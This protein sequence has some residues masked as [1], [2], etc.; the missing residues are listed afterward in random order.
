MHS[1]RVKLIDGGKLVIPAAMRRELGTATGDS[2]VVDL[3]NGELRVRTLRKVIE[4][5]RAI[6]RRYVPEDRSL[7][8]ELLAERREEA[9]RE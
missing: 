9:E 8:D 2:V 3:A 1:Q 7:V 5:A 6:M 4:D